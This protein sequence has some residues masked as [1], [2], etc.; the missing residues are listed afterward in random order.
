MIHGEMMVQ[1]NRQTIFNGWNSK[2]ARKLESADMKNT[3]FPMSSVG[4]KNKERK[5]KNYKQFVMLT[6]VVVAFRS[7]FHNNPTFDV[8]FNSDNK[9]RRKHNETNG[10]C[11]FY[12]FLIH[13]MVF[14]VL[15]RLCVRF[16]QVSKTNRHFVFATSWTRLGRSWS[17]QKTFFYV[18]FS[19]SFDDV[20]AQ[21]G[22]NCQVAIV[23]VQRNVV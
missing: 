21:I 22:I 6:W 7:F 20:D 11:H 16:F 10:I 14:S 9:K 19:S 15:W 8:R 5:I 13:F 17:E 18:V 2:N 3:L 1:R 4:E 12:F 23:Y